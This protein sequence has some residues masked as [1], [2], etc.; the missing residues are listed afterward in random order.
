MTC[1][2]ATLSLS[3][4]CLG[5]WSWPIP[6]RMRRLSFCQFCL[7]PSLFLAL[8]VEVSSLPLL[9]RSVCVSDTIAHRNPDLLRGFVVVRKKD[10]RSKSVSSF[11]SPATAAR[12]ISTSLHHHHHRIIVHDRHPCHYDNDER[13]LK[14]AK[15]VSTHSHTPFEP[16]FPKG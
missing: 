4:Y 9:S 8:H 15:R 7:S 16:H 12:R 6:V 10:C 11:F 3:L 14:L 5:V 13:S 2:S 1:Q